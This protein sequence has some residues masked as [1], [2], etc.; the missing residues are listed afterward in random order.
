MRFS[1][2]F[3]ILFTLLA[4]IGF[5]FIPMLASIRSTDAKTAAIRNQIDQKTGNIKQVLH[6]TELATKRNARLTEEKQR[7]R[8]VRDQMA[9]IFADSAVSES[10]VRSLERMLSVREV[11]LLDLGDGFHKQ[12]VLSVPKDRKFQL[13][14][15]FADGY[16][17]AVGSW[18]QDFE[19]LDRDTASLDPGLVLVD[20]SFGKSNADGANALA[21]LQMIVSIDNK[22]VLEASSTP[23]EFSGV[24]WSMFDFDQQRDY[25]RNAK[26]LPTLVSFQ[27]NSCK[28]TIV[29][30]IEEVQP[31]G[32]EP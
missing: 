16:G 12:F 4:A 28:A 15:G 17:E 30:T 13:R 26:K 1:L 20:C 19:M 5:S 32:D 6:Q 2:K 8:A 9:E 31:A 22:P 10:E 25:G 11:P 23:R 27:P 18:Q 24:S 21:A 7:L 14:L 29:L 3:L